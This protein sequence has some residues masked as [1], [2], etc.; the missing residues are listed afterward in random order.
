M[1]PCR[2]LVGYQMMIRSEAIRGRF[3]ECYATPKPFTPNESAQ[4][5]LPL[6]DMMHTFLAWTPNPDSYPDHLVS[7]D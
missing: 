5:H 4:V 1:A 7:V 3:R 6:L 2:S